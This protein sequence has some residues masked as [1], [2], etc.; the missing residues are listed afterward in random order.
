MGYGLFDSAMP[1]RD[2]RHGRLYIF[3]KLPTVQEAAAGDDWFGYVYADDKRS[4]KSGAPADAGCDCPLCSR[5]SL[6]YLRP[7]FKLNDSLY[8]RLATLHNLRF[9]VRLMNLLRKR[10]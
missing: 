10:G 6:G 2:A 1:T 4:I 8:Y 3:R 7:L 5:Y 9:M